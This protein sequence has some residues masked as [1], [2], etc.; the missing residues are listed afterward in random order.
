MPNSDMFIYCFIYLSEASAFSEG[1]LVKNLIN[2]HYSKIPLKLIFTKSKTKNQINQLNKTISRYNI[3]PYFL[4]SYENENYTEY[5]NSFLKDLLAELEEEKLIDIYQYYYSMN[6][7]ESFK[8]LCLINSLATDLY[9][10]QLKQKDIEP[11]IYLSSKVELYL[12]VLFIKNINCENIKK[13][14]IN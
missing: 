2:D 14:I 4:Q 6:I 5:L 1:N 10:D 3:K 13:K 7:F 9:S 8:N 11:S 12:N